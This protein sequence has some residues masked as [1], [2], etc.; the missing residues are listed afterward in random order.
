ML[1][2]TAAAGVAASVTLQQRRSISVMHGVPE[3][4]FVV[5]N[6]SVLAVTVRSFGSGCPAMVC[7]AGWPSSAAARILEMLSTAGASSFYNGDFDGEGLRIAAHMVARLA[8]RPWR[9]DSSDYLSAV[10]P[11]P[12]V[13]RVT[14]VPWDGELAGHLRRVGTT[15]SQERVIERRSRT[16]PGRCR[17][18]ALPSRPRTEQGAVVDPIRVPPEMFRFT[19]GELSG[20]Y[21]AI[22]LDIEC[23]E[24]ERHRTS[25]TGTVCSGV[26]DS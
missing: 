24:R 1:R 25:R 9:M 15:V 17:W 7:T 16:S 14:D 19:S 13:G 23:R 3:R 2:V 11:G 4:V 12:A 18:V 22:R 21:T 5:E 20:L 10:G 8:G 6:P 26:R